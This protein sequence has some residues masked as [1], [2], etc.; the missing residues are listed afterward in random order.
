M[1]RWS[2]SAHCS[3][4]LVGEKSA[5]LTVGSTGLTRLIFRFRI[6]SSAKATGPSTQ[7]ADA[8]AT[9]QPPRGPTAITQEVMTGPRSLVVCTPVMRDTCAFGLLPREDPHFCPTLSIMAAS[10]TR[11]D[12]TSTAALGTPAGG[13]A[14]AAAQSRLERVES[15]LALAEADLDDKKA[16]LAK[17]Q[18]KYLVAESLVRLLECRAQNVN[19]PTDDPAGL[20]D[21]DEA[22]FRAAREASSHS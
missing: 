1:T 9:S 6:M 2:Y 12:A 19:A 14:V 16:N 10:P 7:A 11:T 22:S 18:H 5:S 4:V 17:A 8:T 15:R 3:R 21:L 20:T 13:D